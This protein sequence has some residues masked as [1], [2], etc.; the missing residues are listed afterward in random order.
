MADYNSSLPVRTET[1]GDVVAKV[2]GAVS[3]NV[4]EVN[5][6]NEQLVKD[7]DVENQLVGIE[8]KLTDGSQVTKITDGTDQLEV[9]ADGSVNTVTKITDGTDQLEVNA[10]GSINV[11]V[12]DAGVSATEKQ[13]YGTTSAGVPNTPSNVVNYTV[14]ALKT[15]LIKKV[16]ASASG[17]CKVELKVGPAASEVTQAVG[18][19]STSNPA[20][21]FT[22]PAP[23]E[24]VA[25]D[26]IL[27]VVT[28][29]DQANQD[30]YAY[31]NG[32]EL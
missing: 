11:V 30:L 27:V 31:V 7:T 10:D 21:E 13:V 23:I 28:N 9:N 2:V 29:K 18:F 32:N 14:T 6:S 26:K 19:N 24:V 5:A 16:Y 4:G 22:F 25:G 1:D 15:F 20:V 17:K 12:Q 3:G 8:T